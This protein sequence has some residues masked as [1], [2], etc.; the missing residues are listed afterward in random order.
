MIS[1]KN[2]F[3]D[4]DVQKEIDSLGKDSFKVSKNLKCTQ[5]KNENDDFEEEI[6]KAESEKSL[7]NTSVLQ[8]DS[9]EKNFE[10]EK[11]NN[12]NGSIESQSKV[13]TKA[14]C[15]KASENQKLT[16]K[17][18]HKD[19]ENDHKKTKIY[20]RE[21]SEK[22][23]EE[24]IEKEINESCHEDLSYKK[25]LITS[26]SQNQTLVNE[27]YCSS[28]S[29]HIFPHKGS[30]LIG[31]QICNENSEQS[32]SLKS[33]KNIDQIDP[34]S[35]TWRP[36]YEKTH[37]DDVLESYRDQSEKSLQYATY[38]ANQDFNKEIQTNAT[39]P[40]SAVQSFHTSNDHL[41]ASN[42]EEVYGRYQSSNIQDLQKN[43]FPANNALLNKNDHACYATY[44]SD[45][46]EKVP[47]L[48]KICNDV[49]ERRNTEYRYYKE[50]SQI[51]DK[52][53]DYRFENLASSPMDVD[54]RLSHNFPINIPREQT[55]TNTFEV[56]PNDIHASVQSKCNDAQKDFSESIEALAAQDIDYRRM[57]FGNQNNQN[58]FQEQPL[59]F[60]SDTNAQV[61]S[62][63]SFSEKTK[64]ICDDSSNV[65]SE[66]P[67]PDESRLTMSN[68]TFESISDAI[69]KIT[70]IPK[71]IPESPN[72]NFNQLKEA[73]KTIEDI[74]K[75]SPT[76]ELNKVNESDQIQKDKIQPANF[77]VFGIF[78]Q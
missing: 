67:E 78:E 52:D 57:P 26:I 6:T 55:S 53:V 71:E 25:T 24:R 9:C 18:I 17:N 11:A 60:N 33:I 62:E 61:C 70:P 27:T 48:S 37:T 59:I 49:D 73:L 30:D 15:S 47:N 4:I 2:V 40:S 75:K 46:L 65:V 5:A 19:F 51:H 45:L 16:E 77:E 56:Q 34:P 21:I 63:S 42:S 31:N 38:N 23:L 35:Q 54:Y 36:L 69:Q 13:L 32:K 29:S 3:K 74:K 39:D 20:E 58:T 41:K 1:G 44:G 8:I 7:K 50:N 10:A 12:S 76:Q 72:I 14:V 22:E 43:L 64:Q 66:L 28:S 68:L